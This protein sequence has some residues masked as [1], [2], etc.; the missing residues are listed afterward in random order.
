MLSSATGDIMLLLCSCFNGSVLVHKALPRNSYLPYCSGH[1]LCLALLTKHSLC[2]YTYCQLILTNGT[3][4]PD[5]LRLAAFARTVQATATLALTATAT[6]RVTQ[7]ICSR[8]SIAPTEGV[9]RT[10][11][12][13]GN[14]CLRAARAP[15][16]FDERVKVLIN[17]LRD[18]R[19]PPGATIVYA[20]LQQTATD[21]A[22]RCVQCCGA[23][24]CCACSACAVYSAV[25]VCE[26]CC[27]S[28]CVL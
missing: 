6:E 22:D 11:L 3:H 27:G 2:C 4:R 21:T 23:S 13:R 5:Y 20:M 8:L 19:R 14:L 9:V 7:D 18:P 17:R 10:P 16:S 15:D 1:C 25:A 28:A 24:H 26:A 12:H